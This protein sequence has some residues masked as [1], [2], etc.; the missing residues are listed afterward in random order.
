MVPRDPGI[1]ELVGKSIILFPVVKN[2][3]KTSE[4]QG[5]PMKNR[6][7]C[8]F[9]KKKKIFVLFTQGPH[10]TLK[11]FDDL[12]PGMACSYCVL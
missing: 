7:K 5:N 11:T 1:R 6:G 12:R 2:P 4:K 9:C 3:M 8:V 10:Y